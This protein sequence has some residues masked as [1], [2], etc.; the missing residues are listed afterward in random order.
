MTRENLLKAAI[1]HYPTIRGLLDEWIDGDTEKG[2]SP[3]FYHTLS[4][5]GDREIEKTV[6]AFD[7][8]MQELANA[9]KDEG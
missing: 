9:M 8:A 7:L 6:L 2:L 4:Y 1:C 5:E 3:T